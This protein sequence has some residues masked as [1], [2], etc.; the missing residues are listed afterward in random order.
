MLARERKEVM[1][2]LGEMHHSETKRPL[3]SSISV[4]THNKWDNLYVGEHNL[5]LGCY[6]LHLFGTSQSSKD[7]IMSFWMGGQVDR[8]MTNTHLACKGGFGQL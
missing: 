7:L 5:L 2:I 6:V 1:V 8:R 4:F 3:T